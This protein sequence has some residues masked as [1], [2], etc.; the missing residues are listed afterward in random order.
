M[1]LRIH[2]CQG[3]PPRAAEDHV[4]LVD[5]HMLADGLDV[6]DQVVGGVLPQLRIWQ[7]LA[8]ATLVEQDDAVD[9]WIEEG[10]V[11]VGA[12]AAGPAVEEDN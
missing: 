3:G 8:G 5:A 11:D 9:L 10:R 7:R 4:P 12:V 6:L 2:Q 1:G